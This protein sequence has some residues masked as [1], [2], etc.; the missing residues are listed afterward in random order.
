MTLRAPTVRDLEGFV[1][2]Q[3]RVALTF[4]QGQTDFSIASESQV[5]NQPLLPGDILW[6]FYCSIL[7]DAAM[8]GKWHVVSRCYRDLQ[9]HADV[10]RWYNGTIPLLDIQTSGISIIPQMDQSAV[11]I[12]RFSDPENDRSHHGAR[13]SVGELQVRHT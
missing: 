10:I 9:A 7:G 3:G 8:D 12:G 2:G 6:I 11:V 5:H 4:Q 13:L 1:P